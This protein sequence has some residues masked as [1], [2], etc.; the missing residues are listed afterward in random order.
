MLLNMFIDLVSKY[1]F[2]HKVYS[3]YKTNYITGLT[4]YG[5][6]LSLQLFVSTHDNLRSDS[7]VDLR[8]SQVVFLI[9][10]VRMTS[11]MGLVGNKVTGDSVNC[12]TG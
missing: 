2:L 9:F 4:N 8:L 3:A 1:N 12:Q 10:E 7:N 11:K 6:L 5:N